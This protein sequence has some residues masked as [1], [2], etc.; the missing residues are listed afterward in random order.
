MKFNVLAALAFAALVCCFAA[1][2][3]ADD[4]VPQI[5]GVTANAAPS[6]PCQECDAC[7]GGIVF[8]G[9][10]ARFGAGV[11]GFDRSE[12][13]NRL[14]SFL[15]NREIVD[16]SPYATPTGEMQDWARFRH[17]PYGYY[18]HNFNQGSSMQLQRFNPAWQNYYPVPRRYH[19]G[20]HFLLDVF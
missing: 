7:E 10:G 13:R 15:Y 1:Q 6:Q 2:A 18:P 3:V 17:Y 9:F 19:E 14:N 8:P 4:A 12:F 5:A 20:K 16:A 11:G